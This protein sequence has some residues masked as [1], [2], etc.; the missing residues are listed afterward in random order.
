MPVLKRGWQDCKKKF[1]LTFIIIY[2]RYHFVFII[3]QQY[4]I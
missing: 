1:E 4:I 3:R 2:L